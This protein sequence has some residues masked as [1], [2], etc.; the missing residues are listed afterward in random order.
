MRVV[1]IAAILLLAAALLTG[2]TTHREDLDPSSASRVAATADERKT[3]LEAVRRLLGFRPGTIDQMSTEALAAATSAAALA[4]SASADR[5]LATISRQYAD[6]LLRREAGRAGLSGFARA[7]AADTPDAAVTGLAALALL[8]AAEAT[9]DARYESAARNAAQAVTD[10]RFGWVEARDHVGVAVPADEVATAARRTGA[11]RRISIALTATAWWLLRRT[12]DVLD[13]GR[14][15]DTV[16]GNQAAVG[17]WYAIL[18]TRVPMGLTD[19]ATTLNAVIADPSRQSQGV[20][21]AGVPAIYAAAF[22]SDGA[23]AER[24]QDADAQG[25]ALALGVVAQYADWSY[26]ARAFPAITDEMR[27]DGR[28]DLGAD[29]PTAQAYFAL[30]FAR[31]LATLTS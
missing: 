13:A 25:V 12:G 9:G 31:R 27:P 10:P 23:V 4:T 7:A 30:A 11:R 22:E 28:I 24:R 3:A 29:M 18:G 2:C 8:D 19:W 17:R 15:R 26:A 6:A 21:G 14:A 1:P 5:D 16:L 20:L